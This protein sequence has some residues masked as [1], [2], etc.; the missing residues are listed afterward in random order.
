MTDRHVYLDFGDPHE[1]YGPVGGPYDTCRRCGTKIVL[2]PSGR[3]CLW[4]R[5]FIFK[6]GAQKSD[7]PAGQFPC[8]PPYE[9][10]EA[11]G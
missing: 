11:T 7:V 2:T 6:D 5:T 1:W 10:P 8:C 3:G 4:G 9:N